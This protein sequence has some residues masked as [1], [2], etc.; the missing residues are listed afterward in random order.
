MGVDFQQE[1]NVKSSLRNTILQAP[2]SAKLSTAGVEGEA[3]IV[4][5]F[6]DHLYYVPVKVKVK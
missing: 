5:K 2:Q 6:Y 3:S 1:G 4:Y